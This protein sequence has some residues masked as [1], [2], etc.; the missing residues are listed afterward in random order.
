MHFKS[1]VH[2]LIWFLSGSTNIQYLKDNNVRIWNEWADENG[3][4]RTSMANNGV[5]G[6]SLM[7][8]S[9]TSCNKAI[10]LIKN[11]PLVVL[12]CQPGTQENW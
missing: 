7:A 11:D 9:L 3:E 1:I 6:K 12:W 4:G 8:K 10:D 2:E 5:D